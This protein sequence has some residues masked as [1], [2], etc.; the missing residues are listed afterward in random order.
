MMY[1]SLQ[2]TFGKSFPDGL[3]SHMGEVKPLKVSNVMC[4]SICK[5]SGS[6]TNI[7]GGEFVGTTRFGLHMIIVI[8]LC[9]PVIDVVDSGL[10]YIENCPNLLI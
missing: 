10:M 2:A 4:L 6:N 5:H 9:V 1:V 7:T 3:S 8:S